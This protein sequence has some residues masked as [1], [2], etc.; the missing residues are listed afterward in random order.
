MGEFFK[1]VLRLFG[2]YWSKVDINHKLTVIFLGT[3]LTIGALSIIYYSSKPAFG[4]LYGS[5]DSDS[6]ASVKEFLDDEK[7]L[8][9]IKDGGRTIEIPKDKIYSIRLS[10]AGKGLPK[11]GKAVGFEIFDK[12]SLGMTEFVQKINYYRA[13]QGELS[14]TIESIEGIDAARVHIVVP[15]ESIFKEDQ[16][17][18]TASIALQ[19]RSQ[20]ILD[21]TQIAGIRQ[22]VASSIEG[23]KANN[24]SIIDNWGN[25]LAQPTSGDGSVG[26]IASSQI[27]LQKSVEKHYVRKIESLLRG[28][29]GNNNAVVRIDAML[30]F[31]KVEKTLESYDPES[32]VVRQETIT[33]ENSKGKT[34]SGEGPPGVQA[35][36]RGN[37]GA[38]ESSKQE[39][40]TSREVIK[41]TYE[42]D[43]FS[44]NTRCW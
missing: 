13:A 31:D 26:D 43:N 17:D 24:I 25:M 28:V 41:N 27:G 11:K 40:S 21:S 3:F 15:E 32:A 37:E 29:L 44:H 9:K 38:S 4:V 5:L 14:R 42:I 34:A 16:K 10:L 39:S 35:N 7:I 36:I 19:L 12:S 22:L 1:R 23:L 6:A 20:G 8:Y 18:A 2:E 33:S 30:N